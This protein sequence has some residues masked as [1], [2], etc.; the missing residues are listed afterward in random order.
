MSSLP[1]S[2]SGKNEQ[3]DRNCEFLD[4]DACTVKLSK[5]NFKK[6][7][8]LKS[9]KAGHFWGA[10]AGGVVILASSASAQNLFVSSYSDSTIYEMKPDGTRQVFA[11]GYGVYQ[12]YFLAFDNGGNLFV[13]SGGIFKFAHDGTQTLFSGSFAPYGIAFNSAG[14]LFAS[15]FAYTGNIYKFTST[16]EQRLFASRLI[17]PTGLAFDRE[18]NLWVSSVG[19]DPGSGKIYKIAP[20]GTQ[21]LFATDL[22]YPTGL[23]F[24]RMGNLFVA[25][26]QSG[27][28]EEFKPDGTRSTFASGLFVPEQIAFDGDGNLF[29]ANYGGG[30]PGSVTEITP[31]GIKSTFADFNTTGVAFKPGSTP[32]PSVLALMSVGTV[33]ILLGRKRSK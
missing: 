12:P 27:S 30:G 29:V 10:V 1:G 20:D 6:S 4:T 23:A 5:R 8:K 19:W 25:E 21:S 15:D 24:D 31:D 22:G 13:A 18:G 7:V 3:G 11:S 9:K 16:G 32:E 28:V 17:G 2:N 26:D 33:A 14:E